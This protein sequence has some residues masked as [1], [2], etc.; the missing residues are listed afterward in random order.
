MKMG[1]CISLELETGR[2]V[3]TWMRKNG[4][5]NFSFAIDHLVNA[6]LSSRNNGVGA[7]QKKLLSDVPS[8]FEDVLIEQGI[9]KARVKK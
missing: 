1:K 5:A 8:I 3:E 6:G 4:V 7:I 9:Q 2:K